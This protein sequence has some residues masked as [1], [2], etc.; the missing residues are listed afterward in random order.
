MPVLPPLVRVVDE[1]TRLPRPAI[2]ER[3][4]LAVG[5]MIKRK[6]ESAVSDAR[7]VCV[8]PCC[9]RRGNRSL[10]DAGNAH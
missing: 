5:A 4:D 8:T 10:A 6:C 2:A 1:L 9:D 7:G 3:R